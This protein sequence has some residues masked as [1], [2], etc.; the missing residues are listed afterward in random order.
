LRILVIHYHFPGQFS[1][2]LAATLEDPENQVIAISSRRHWPAGKKYLGRVPVLTY[3]PNLEGATHSHRFARRL[4]VEVRHGLPVARLA[5]G[6]RQRGF[7]PDIIL[8][9][10]GW[11]EGLFLRD[12][13]PEGR[14]V[15][16]AEYYFQ[17][18]GG[19]AGFDPEYPLTMDDR[20]RLRTINATNLLSL[21][22]CD[23]AVSATRWQKSRFPAEFRHKIEVIHEG[24]DTSLIKPNARAVLR[25]PDGRR[26]SREDEVITY[27]ARN[28]EP[29]RGFHVLMRALPGLLAMRPKAH[30]VIVGGDG[31]SYSHPPQRG[32]NF[33]QI[34]LDELGDRLDATRVHFLPTMPFAELLKVYQVSTV[35]IYL[36]YPFVLSWSLLEAMAAGCAVVASKTPPVEEIIKPGRT[37]E[38]IDFFD[39]DALNNTVDKLARDR[40]NCAELGKSARQSVRKGFDSK[41]VCVPSWQNL[42]HRLVSEA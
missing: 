17:P 12:I 4:D 22:A 38:L 7:V 33:R 28:L 40:E 32:R 15:M 8:V 34:L 6:L 19:A 1:K 36:T 24:I 27:V 39:A 14:I 37:G 23:R 5:Q 25:L 30:V 21:V 13:F 16:L 18:E 26:L 35:H 41:T 10:P 20:L 11:G 42:L 31:V 9:H 3:E 29:V 2:L